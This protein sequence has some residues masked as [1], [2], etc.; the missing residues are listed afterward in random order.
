MNTDNQDSNPGRGR[1]IRLEILQPEDLENPLEN[2]FQVALN[3]NPMTDHDRQ[4]GRSAEEYHQ[5]AAMYHDIMVDF[6]KNVGLP[7]DMPMEEWDG[8]IEGDIVPTM[9][10]LREL[11]DEIRTPHRRKRKMTSNTDNYW[12]SPIQYIID[13]AMPES[14][15]AAIRS[16]ITEWESLTCL[17]FQQTSTP[18]GNY[19]QIIYGNGCWSSLGMRQGGQLLSLGLGC[20]SHGAAI[21]E[22]AHAI[23][24]HHE[25]VRTDRDEHITVHYE[26]VIAGRE[27]NFHKKNQSNFDFFDDIPYD[28]GSN[29]HYRKRAFF[30][31]SDLDLLTI[32]TVIPVYENRIGDQSKLSFYDALTAN[33]A[34][35]NGDASPCQAKGGLLTP[36]CQHGGYWNPNNCDVCI[37]PAGLAG[38]RCET[39]AP[40]EGTTEGEILDISC[41]DSVH[42]FGA[43]LSADTNKQEAYW[44]LRAPASATISFQLTSI[45]SICYSLDGLT[46][47]TR[48]GCP[49]WLEVKYLDLAKAGPW[50][51]VANTY[52]Y[53]LLKSTQNEIILIARSTHNADFAF[54]FTYEAQC[55]DCYCV[56]WGPYSSCDVANTPNNCGCTM[57]KR[58]C[59][60]AEGH[61]T[62]PIPD[63][64]VYC[65]PIK[66]VVAAC[67][68]GEDGPAYCCDDW[69]LLKEGENDMCTFHKCS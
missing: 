32:E 2:K 19:L 42:F 9:N 49:D 56:E 14:H 17:H 47:E 63:E 31:S 59:V 8:L 45:S 28:L 25:H 12:T 48:L 66:K 3:E 38:D 34:Y 1:I 67:I 6:C 46:C 37:C 39:V 64:H 51:C 18:V 43:Q 23:G 33:L 52:G 53:P 5:Q 24:F 57:Q 54:E 7:E 40:S 11:R 36:E 58:S 30:N 68:G 62:D 20:G 41:G 44:L 27:A 10:D 26:N 16:A 61:C 35:C 69:L 65:Q 21:H 15:V 22:L 4:R 50:F 13:A 55:P 60:R 29:M